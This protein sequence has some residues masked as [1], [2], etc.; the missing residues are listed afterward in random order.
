MIRLGRRGNWKKE[1]NNNN[2]SNK[3]DRRRPF[4]NGFLTFKPNDGYGRGCRACAERFVARTEFYWR[5]NKYA[6][7]K[8]INICSRARFSVRT[9]TYV[10]LLQCIEIDVPTGKTGSRRPFALSRIYIFGEKGLE[11]TARRRSKRPK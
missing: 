7:K 5:K 3:R 10:Y 9:N 1:V 11:G 4:G 6:K 2:N 8:L